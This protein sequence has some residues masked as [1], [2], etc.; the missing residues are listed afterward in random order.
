MKFY[1]NKFIW[2]YIYV[3]V[4]SIVPYIVI[5]NTDTKSLEYIKTS[6]GRG[7]ISNPASAQKP[8]G[9]IVHKKIAYRYSLE[10]L[11]DV[12]FLLEQIYD[13]LIIKQERASIVLEYCDLRISRLQETKRGDRCPYGDKEFELLQKYKDSYASKKV[14]KWKQ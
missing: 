9:G 12:K 10:N 5:S 4:R 1:K 6:I 7:W 14:V 8:S 3:R 2:I 11:A 13:Y